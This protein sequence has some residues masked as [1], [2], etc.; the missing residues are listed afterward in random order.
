MN[1]LITLFLETPCIGGVLCKYKK[2]VFNDFSNLYAEAEPVEG[3]Q[4]GQGD[5]FSC[6][7]SCSHLVE[8][9]CK[10]FCCEEEILLF[11]FD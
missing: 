10:H 5:H 4:N 11:M 9:I 3:K 1:L 7:K 2:S 8:G 6:V